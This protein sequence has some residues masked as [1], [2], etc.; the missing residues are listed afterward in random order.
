MR[1]DSRTFL[2]HTNASTRSVT[3]SF[4]EN[5]LEFLM[6]V[7]TNLYSDTVLAPIREYSSNALDSHKAAGVTLPIEVSLPTNM[8]R[9]FV[10]QDFGLGM[11]VDDLFN[12][13]AKYGYSTKR[14]NDIETG[15][16]GLGSKSGLTYTDQFSVT[17]RKN[18]REVIATVAR[19][20]SGAGTINVLVEQD[21]DE[22]NGV[23]V[24]IP[25]HDVDGFNRKALN[26]FRWWEPGTV[27]IDG[28][29]PEFPE[30]EA[31]RVSDEITIYKRH[32]LSTDYVVMGCVAYPVDDRLSSD[33]PYGYHVVA[34]VPMGSVNFPP[35]R[36]EL[37]YTAKT[38][39]VIAEL[40][41][42]RKRLTKAV[43]ERDI[44]TA[45]TY[46]DA[47]RAAKTWEDI[48]S[49]NPQYKGVAVPDTIVV[50]TEKGDNGY[51][52]RPS[53]YLYEPRRYRNKVQRRTQI[54]AQSYVNALVVVGFDN[55]T[56]SPS[57]RRK[58]D[59]YN[60]QRNE[61]P[62]RVVVTAKDFAGVWSDGVDVV[63][64]SVIKAIK[65]PRVQRTRT[66]TVGAFEVIDTHG[67][68]T[69]DV[70][71]IEADDIIVLSP[72][73]INTNARG[74]D[75]VYFDRGILNK[76]WPD[77]TFAV[78]ATNRWNKF[79]REND[80]VRTIKDAI[81][82]FADEFFDSLNDF[83]RAALSGGAEKYRRFGVLDSSKVDDPEVAELINQVSS[84]R[85]VSEDTHRIR[86]V[87]RTVGAE[88]PETPKDSGRFSAVLDKYPLAGYADGKTAEHTQHYIN[89]VYADGKDNS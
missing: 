65:L 19:G 34:Y 36:E 31:I 48:I 46:A 55:Q 39:K 88:I 26:F 63:D 4:D 81:E 23:T 40:S 44:A 89:L 85:D 68:R 43:A 27:L 15:M 16:L 38:N 42:R 57:N 14:D 87:A 37:Q 3:M 76:L 54:E 10:V 8:T 73:H 41:E 58:I 52:Y 35:N 50:P 13:Y 74:W 24:S 70:T 32:V 67:N 83:E 20:E 56:L 69:R 9:M 1:A 66:G 11:D 75:D 49:V 45:P 51:L 82:D 86:S 6:D 22:P 18:G 84:A 77:T 53:F 59:E 61:S 60:S 2:N 30:N 79:I 28:R 17:A 25:V 5:S 72:A 80:N 64:W 29:E 33:L 21:T 7:M 12:I 78:L 62:G 47:I 71:E